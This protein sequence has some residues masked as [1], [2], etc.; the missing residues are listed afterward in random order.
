MEQADFGA[1]EFRARRERVAE[2][3]GEQ[4][5]AV[6]QGADADPAMGCFRQ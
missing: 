1:D 2:A 3:I 4:A 6:V 5:L